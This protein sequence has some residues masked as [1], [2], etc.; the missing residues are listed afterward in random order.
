MTLLTKPTPVG[1]AYDDAESTTAMLEGDAFDGWENEGGYFMDPQD[2]LSQQSAASLFPSETRAFL[3]D[4]FPLGRADRSTPTTVGLSGEIDISTSPA[5]RTSLESVL[6]S[7]TPLLILNL[8][9]VSFCDASGLTVIVGI[10]R[11]ARMMGITLA[12]TAPRPFMSKLL[13]ITGLDRS[14]PMV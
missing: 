8:S 11:R 13:H 9:N 10:Q 4:A 6:K 12:L 1:E 5:L 7:S 2:D 3:T 14:L